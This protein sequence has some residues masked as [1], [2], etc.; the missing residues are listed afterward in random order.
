M[1]Q[2]SFA[3]RRDTSRIMAGRRAAF[4]LIFGED[5]SLLVSAVSER[6]QEA[7]FLAC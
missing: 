5:G 2:R 3:G 7:V 4:Q 6:K 1:G